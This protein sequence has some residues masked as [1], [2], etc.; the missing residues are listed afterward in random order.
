VADESTAIADAISKTKE[1]LDTYGKLGM[2]DD[3]KRTLAHINQ[4]NYSP[5]DIFVARAVLETCLTSLREAL[6]HLL[7]QLEISLI[8]RQY[9]RVL[10]AARACEVFQKSRKDY[11]TSAQASAEDDLI[12]NVSIRDAI[13]SLFNKITSHVETSDTDIAAPVT[14]IESGEEKVSDTAPVKR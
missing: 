5:Q 12:F 8:E 7:S 3:L 9:A 14:D 1:A 2:G 13:L 4:Y 10:A 6:P 11:W